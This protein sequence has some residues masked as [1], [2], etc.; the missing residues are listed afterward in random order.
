[1]NYSILKSRTFWTVVAM[2]IVGG[3]NAIAH[4]LPA[5]LQTVVMG[6]LSL[7]TMYFHINPS[8]SYNAPQQ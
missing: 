1:M 7:A 6:A 8:Q 4:V 2:F 5:D 3:V